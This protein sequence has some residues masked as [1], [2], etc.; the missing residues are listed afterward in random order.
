MKAED[1]DAGVHYSG[2]PWKMLVPQSI[3]WW[4]YYSNLREYYVM[5]NGHHCC[6][7]EEA[8]SLLAEHMSWYLP[9]VKLPNN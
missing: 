6:F 3:Y 1:E 8:L 5:K 4:S 2:L 7:E 9:V